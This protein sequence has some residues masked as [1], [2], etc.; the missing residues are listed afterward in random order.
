M[1][2]WDFYRH[3]SDRLYLPYYWDFYLCIFKYLLI[4]IE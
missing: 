4:I 3:L 1:F 2:D